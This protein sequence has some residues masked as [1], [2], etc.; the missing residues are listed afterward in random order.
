MHSLESL[1]DGGK[2]FKFSEPFFLRQ[3]EPGDMGWVAHRHG[4]LYA[5]QYGWDER[6][7][8]LVAQIVAENSRHHQHPANKV[9]IDPGSS[10][11]NSYA[12]EKRI[13]RQEKARQQPRLGKD[14]PGK[15]GKAKRTG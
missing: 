11:G 10:A 14:N 5:Q 15:P 3:H 9:H 2:S 12:E 7:E 4:L 6:F 1:L 8:A 13:T